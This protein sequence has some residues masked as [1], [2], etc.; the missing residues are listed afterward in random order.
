VRKVIYLVII[1]LLIVFNSVLYYYDAANIDKKNVPAHTEFISEISEDQ[2]SDEFE[3]ID[4]ALFRKNFEKKWIYTKKTDSLWIKYVKAPDR[5]SLARYNYFIQKVFRDNSIDLYKVTEHELSNKLIYNFQAE[6]SIPAI[7]EFKIT[8]SI[9]CDSLKLG[10]NLAIIISPMGENWGQQWIRK[11]IESPLPMAV[12]I[13]PGRWASG[14]IAKEAVKNGKEVMICLPM[15][16]ESGNIDREKYK[17]L[18]NMNEFTVSVVLDR[19]CTEISGALGV[20]SYRGSLVIP[21]YSTMDALFKNMK[22]RN[23][24]YIE[25][26][27]QTESYSP[28]LSEQYGVPF[29]ITDSDISFSTDFEKELSVLVRNVSD[30]MDI[31]MVLDADEKKYNILNKYINEENDFNTISVSQFLMV[32]R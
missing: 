10:G 28:L 4:H 1:S 11:I 2:P 13:L 18:K 24:I 6:D 25:N 27:V 9:E 20:I 23:Y 32:K 16:P 31:L 17:I 30:G 19:I 3:K 5:Y 29:G 22:K 21:D 26:S 14:E 12:G 8:N 7:L 15:E